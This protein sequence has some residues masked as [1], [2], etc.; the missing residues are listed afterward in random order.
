MEEYIYYFFNFKVE[1]AV[2]EI[3]LP[4]FQR[5][6]SGEIEIYKTGDYDSISKFNDLYCF[7]K[8]VNL[9]QF[10][11]NIYKAEKIKELSYLSL[12]VGEVVAPTYKFHNCLLSKEMEENGETPIYLNW[13]DVLNEY[14]C[15][16][17]ALRNEFYCLKS[18][19]E[20]A[21]SK[22]EID[23]LFNDNTFLL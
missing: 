23:S 18:V 9:N 5:L 2:T 6:T 11:L 4:G 3:N 21:T 10:D 1:T 19:V 14:K 16:R 12:S 13:R 15:K 7:A 22:K 8:N 17:I 20:K